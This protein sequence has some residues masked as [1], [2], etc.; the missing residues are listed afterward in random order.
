M[1]GIDAITSEILQDA[2]KS[3]Q[4]LLDAART[5]AE[6]TIASAQASAEKT[7]RDAERRLEVEKAQHE[8][9]LVSRQQ[10]EDRQEKLAWRQGIISVVLQKAQ[11]ELAALPAEQYFSMLVDLVK[12]HAEPNAGTILFS[13]ADLA[14]LP[15]GFEAELQKAA[16]AAG[17]SLKVGKEPADIKDGFILRYGGIDEN[18]TLDALFAQY[19]DKMQDAVQ[20]TLWQV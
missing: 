3:A 5:D 2:N 19:R 12:T 10:M 15:K 1:A 13:A 6:S 7:A 14:R 8:Q 4:E 16:E 18:C 9:R 20:K 17:G 11:E